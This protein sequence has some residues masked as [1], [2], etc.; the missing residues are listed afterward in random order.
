M[1]QVYDW[2]DQWLQHVGVPANSASD[3]DFISAISACASDATY[4]VLWVILFNAVDDFGI[5]EVNELHA[6]G[7]S[8]SEVP[9]YEQVESTKEKLLD[10]AL[11]GALRISGLAGV[12]ASNGYLRLDTAVMHVSCIQAGTLLARLGRPEVK[13]CIAA[14]EQYSFAYEEAAEQGKE[15]ERTYDSAR[16]GDKDFSHMSAA[17][18]HLASAPMPTNGERRV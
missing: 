8:P 17:V 10:E 9:E 4:H 7:S 18:A 13:N 5:R 15:I 1:T 14:L 11:H 16:N 12:L 6:A 3:W 2:R